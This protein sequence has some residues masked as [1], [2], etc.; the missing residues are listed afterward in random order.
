MKAKR[1]Y[2]QDGTPARTKGTNRRRG[3]GSSQK[4][5]VARDGDHLI[6]S[7]LHFFHAELNES[8]DDNPAFR[9]R[10]KFYAEARAALK[11]LVQELRVNLPSC[12]KFHYLGGE[13]QEFVP[14]TNERFKELFSNALDRMFFFRKEKGGYWSRRE[15]RGQRNGEGEISPIQ[16]VR[17]FTPIPLNLLMKQIVKEAA[18]VSAEEFERVQELCLTWGDAF[19]PEVREH[20]VE[21]TA[22]KKLPEGCL[23]PKSACE[24][25]G[26]CRHP[27]GRAS[28]RR[29]QGHGHIQQR[30]ALFPRRPF[31]AGVCVAVD[32]DSAGQRCAAGCDR[33]GASGLDV[34]RGHDRQGD[35]VA[36]EH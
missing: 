18:S 24:F 30:R 12:E 15:L 8:R 9:V 33:A 25:L 20:V 5:A 21:W 2:R 6:D 10:S 7:A 26:S 32:A 16:T 4:N 19:A 35:H 23:D 22:T 28:L 1:I 14:V 27:G 34:S 3:K 13:A 17:I 11:K 31:A 29:R 36:A